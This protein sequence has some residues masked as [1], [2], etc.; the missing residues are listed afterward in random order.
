MYLTSSLYWA[1]QSRLT[2]NLDTDAAVPLQEAVVDPSQVQRQMAS[3]GITAAQVFASQEEEELWFDGA[4]KR[5]A[6][7]IAKAR[8]KTA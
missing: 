4:A 2:T 3:T 8:R 5:G 6:K 7:A 1:F